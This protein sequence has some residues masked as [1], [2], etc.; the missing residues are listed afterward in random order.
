M[1]LIQSG[2]FI[3]LCLLGFLIVINIRR[4]KTPLAF[5]L[6]SFLVGVSGWSTGILFLGVL[7]I[8]IRWFTV[9]PLFVVFIV[10]LLMRAVKEKKFQFDK[11]EKWGI[12]LAAAVSVAVIAFFSFNVYAFATPDTYEYIHAGKSFAMLD[13]N[14]SARSYIV[15]G[16][17]LPFAETASVLLGL[18]Y[19]YGLIPTMMTLFWVT[20]I[21]LF[22]RGYEYVLIGKKDKLEIHFFGD[23]VIIPVAAIFTAISGLILASNWFFQLFTFFIHTNQLS[24]IYLTLTFLTTWFALE[25]AEKS[26]LILSA[27]FGVSLS[28]SRIETFFVALLPLLFVVEEKRFSPRTIRQVYLPGNILIFLWSVRKFIEAVG[29]QGIYINQ[30]Y[31]MGI[32]LISLAAVL[33]IIF[34]PIIQNW[35]FRLSQII[36]IGLGV[37]LII[38]FIIQPSFMFHS[39]LN[40]YYN[41]FKTSTWDYVWYFIFP[42]FAFCLLTPTRK[43]EN[44]FQIGLIIY[45]FLVLA[46]SLIRGTEYNNALWYDSGNRMFFH[47]FPLM[48]F[49]PISKLISLSAND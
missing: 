32:T 9:V 31:T 23:I 26:W 4:D 38:F 17:L 34:H 15:F 24:M 46:L 30:T 27:I 44:L 40:L 47:I 33:F 18:D 12:L 43:Y 5:F 45:M 35:K 48:L 3:F 22:Y 41:L 19:L 2:F 10:V 42:F 39:T 25:K 36:M 14:A 29:K 7:R 16:P 20:M 8:P 28:I 49:Y 6:G 1:G 11:N 37:L 13:W 21:P